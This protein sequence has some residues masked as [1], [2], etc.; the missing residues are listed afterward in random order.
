MTD[1]TVFATCG[2]G[3]TREARLNTSV[4]NVRGVCCWIVCVAL[5]SVLAAHALAQSKP[6][7]VVQKPA[8]AVAVVNGAAISQMQFDRALSNSVAQG[9]RDSPELRQAIREEL[10]ARE[11]LS[12]EAV[13]QKLD[14]GND[15][16]ALLA[17]ARQNVLIDLLIAD[18][19][20]KNPISD[21]Q[22]EA[23][24]QR[25]IREVEERGGNQQYR[26]R[27]VTVASEAE[28]RAIIGRIRRGESMEAIARQSSIAPNKE[29]GGL[30]DWLSPLQMLP[31]V[32]SVVANLSAGAVAAAPILTQ[33]A[34]SVIRVE[35]I[36]PFQAPGLDQ[37][38]DQ[39]RAA[40]VR[41]RQGALIRSLRASAQV[42]E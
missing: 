27:Q 40:L 10:I 17:I 5:A 31:S 37:L 39:M 19:L 2:G 15:A 36:R 38:R 32:A 24:Y 13:R 12:Q 25:Q 21:S 14:R 18:H 6:A 9:Q 22:I 23:E 7:A 4:R 20:S 34:W 16:S 29:Q 11:V 3:A 8:G 26:L 41:E 42:V 35:D 33:D 30:L 28:A 1:Q